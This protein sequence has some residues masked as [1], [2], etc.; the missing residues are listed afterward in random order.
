MFSENYHTIYKTIY[1]HS[2]D[3]TKE[4]FNKAFDYFTIKAEE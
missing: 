3:T 2:S 4:M 1:R